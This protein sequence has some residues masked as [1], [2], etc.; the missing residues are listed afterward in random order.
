MHKAR[1]KTKIH[2][3]INLKN[4]TIKIIPHKIKIKILTST[5]TTKFLK[6]TTIKIIR[7]TNRTF[8]S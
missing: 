3:E 8:K 6:S 7:K 5:Q 2:I 4:K 1:I